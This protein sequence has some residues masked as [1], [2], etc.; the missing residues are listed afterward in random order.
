MKIHVIL[1]RPLRNW[2]TT[3]GTTPSERQRAYPGDALLPN[4]CWSYTHGVTV[5][6]PPGQVW[7]WIVQI[8]Q[9]CG[10]FYS[11]ELL[12]NLVGC[13][14]TNA[15]QILPHC[16][17]LEV[18]DSI[19]LHPKAPPLT[20]AM[21]EVER[22]LV[23]FASDAQSGDSTVWGFHL[24]PEG[25]GRTRLI[26]RGGSTHGE[27]LRS[28]LTF[29]RLLLEPISFVMS[30]KMLLTIKALSPVMTDSV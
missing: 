23:L 12:E 5:D 1:G 17:N 21:M 29:G 14:I 13:R 9:G 2:R 3:W 25:S 28:R 27:S 20:V 22:H 7:P 4:P 30:R 24:T 15:N 26:E 18:G 10:G 11:Y 6:A 16:Q 8:G 19:R